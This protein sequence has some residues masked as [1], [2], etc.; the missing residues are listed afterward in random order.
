MS[1]PKTNVDT[2]VINMSLNSKVEHQ[3]KER[4]TLINGQNKNF[5]RLI[6]VL[7]TKAF[8]SKLILEERSCKRVNL[9]YTFSLLIKHD[10]TSSRDHFMTSAT[11]LFI[12]SEQ[13]S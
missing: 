2:T 6:Y 8:K 5:D 11:H 13:N 12:L 9:R 4:N 7:F 1:L 3:T 10:K